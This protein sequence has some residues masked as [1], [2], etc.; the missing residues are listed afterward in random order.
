[1]KCDELFL[2]R[3]PQ[4]DAEI[5]DALPE[6]IRQEIKSAYLSGNT[7]PLSRYNSLEVDHPLGRSEV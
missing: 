6:D 4:L 3:T 7:D 5:M 1:V 2:F